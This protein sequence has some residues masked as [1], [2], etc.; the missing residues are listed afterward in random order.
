MTFREFTITGL[1]SAVTAGAV[2]YVND[3]GGTEQVVLSKDS[4]VVE[5]KGAAASA[6]LLDDAG[7]AR[8]FPPG[9]VVTCKAGGILD[10]VPRPDLEWCSDGKGQT[11][12]RPAKGEETIQV[13]GGKVFAAPIQQ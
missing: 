11:W 9:T 8:P 13:V 3:K 12:T 5:V 7:Q 4:P 2:L 1:V 10:R 6:V